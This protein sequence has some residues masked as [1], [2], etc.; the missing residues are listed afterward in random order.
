MST[1]SSNKLNHSFFWTGEISL[2]LFALFH[3][4]LY[5]I[6][7]NNLSTSTI[8]PRNTQVFLGFKLLKEFFITP[9]VHSTQEIQARPVQL[10][11]N[12]TCFAAIYHSLDGSF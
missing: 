8:A 11:E 2:G 6:L 7:L 5:C 3:T 12:K 4:E 9:E 1:F 10:A